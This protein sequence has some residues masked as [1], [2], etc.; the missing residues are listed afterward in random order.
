MISFFAL[1]VII[2]FVVGGIFISGLSIFAE[3]T[4]KKAAGI[5]LSLPSTV[6][7]SYF[8]IGWTL[9]PKAVSEIVPVTIAGTGLVL[10]FAITYLY[11]SKIKIPKIISI[12]LSTIL[13]LTV[14]FMGAVPLA[15]LEFSSLI[16]ALVVYIPTAL[17]GYYFL[18]IK[19]KIVALTK[20]PTYSLK[21]KIGRALFGGTI[22]ALAVFFAKTLSPFWGGV[23]AGF[24]A[25]FLSTLII[26]HRQHDSEY[27]LRVF[28]NIPLGLLVTIS[29]PLAASYTYPAFGIILG[30]IVAYITSII[31]GLTVYKVT[32]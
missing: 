10:A 17:I 4:N 15:I 8:F 23:F 22:I 3:R 26:L 31:I 32:N 29:F 9:T 21:E 16:M 6:L 1:Q 27:L 24:P 18:T 5:I 11:T 30:S 7:I 20:K 28:H 13:G 14:W 2:S 19:P 25:L 12:F